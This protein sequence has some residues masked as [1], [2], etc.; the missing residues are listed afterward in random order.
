MAATD[1]L[2]SLPSLWVTTG[3]RVSRREG[4]DLPMP[5]LEKEF[6]S[7]KHWWNE[8]D[9]F[10]GEHLRFCEDHNFWYYPSEGC[11]MC[12]KARESGSAS[13]TNVPGQHVP[14]P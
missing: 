14:T 3:S 11:Y 13:S 5:D 1:S 9:H 7:P 12:K 10:R 6:F 8:P 4:F 2:T